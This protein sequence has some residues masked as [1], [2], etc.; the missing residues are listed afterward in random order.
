MPSL[1]DRFEKTIATRT[2]QDSRVAPVPARQ[3]FHGPRSNNQYPAPRIC[4]EGSRTKVMRQTDEGTS[5]NHIV[6]EEQLIK[7]GPL[8][9]FQYSRSMCPSQ[10]WKAVP[11]G[12]PLSLKV[13]CRQITRREQND[14][15]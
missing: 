9:F 15:M 4:T 3:S 7:D 2:R 5:L 1:D 6:R 10:A 8:W 14:I 13:E 11:R 12:L